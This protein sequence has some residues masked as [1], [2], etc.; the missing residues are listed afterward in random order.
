MGDLLQVVSYARQLEARVAALERLDGVPDASTWTPALVF[1]GAST[2]ITYATQTGRYV[3]MGNLIWF[4]GTIW[5]T[6]KGSATGTAGVT[7]LPSGAVGHSAVALMAFGVSGLAGLLQ[8]VVENSTSAIL[9]YD[10]AHTASAARAT[11]A[12]F[13]DASA[14]YMSGVYQVA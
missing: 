5:L 8:A 13:A 2:G 1:G 9:F 3:R 11:N 7:G 14:V 4:S 12:D 6:S 10:M